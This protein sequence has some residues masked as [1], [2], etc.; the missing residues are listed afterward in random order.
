MVKRSIGGTDKWRL[1]T[2]CM[3]KPS[4][5]RPPFHTSAAVLIMAHLDC[6]N[7]LRPTSAGACLLHDYLS[8]THKYS[9][10]QSCCERLASADVVRSTTMKSE[11]A[12]GLPVRAVASLSLL[13]GKD[14][15]ISSIFAHFPVVSLIF[16]LIFLI[17]SFWSSGWTARPHG[18]ATAPSWGISHFSSTFFILFC[19]KWQHLSIQIKKNCNF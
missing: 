19:H 8:C 11:C 4:E 10:T 1:Y 18:K 2:V 5:F 13:G 14:K 12:I 7:L 3:Y 6:H 17:S 9:H 15:N 16:P